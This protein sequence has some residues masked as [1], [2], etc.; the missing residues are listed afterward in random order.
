VGAWLDLSGNRLTALP[1]EIGD[2]RAWH[3]DVSNNALT[4]LPADV[5]RLMKVTQF[6]AAGNRLESLPPGI[7]NAGRINMLD[8]RDNCLTALPADCYRLRETRALRVRCAGNP[9]PTEETE[10]IR[11]AFPRPFE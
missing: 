2:I 7:Q 4:A 10:R 11:H 9:F 6:L 1:P 5:W 3:V 8:V